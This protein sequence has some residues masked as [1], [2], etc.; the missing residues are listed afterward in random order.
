MTQKEKILSILDDENWHCTNEFYASYMADPRKR[1]H[2]L[3][4]KFTLEWRWCEQH[5]HK[6]SKEWRL[7]SSPD[8]KTEAP[9]QPPEITIEEYLDLT[10]GPAVKQKIIKEAF[11]QT[12]LF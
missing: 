4:Q 1:L 9:T 10:F 12:S 6:G 2:E 5:D 8:H 7:M 3:R 11:L